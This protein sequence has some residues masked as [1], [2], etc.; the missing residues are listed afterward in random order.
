[1]PLTHVQ[2]DKQHVS[3]LFTIEKRKKIK[4]RTLTI[5]TITFN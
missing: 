1:M 3:H 2:T 5:T 4:E